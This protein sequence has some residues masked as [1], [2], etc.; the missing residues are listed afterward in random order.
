VL[1]EAARPFLTDTVYKREKHPFFGPPQL[2]GRILDL[3]R[4]TLSS[5]ILDEQPFFDAGAVRKRLEIVD[6]VEGRA[7]RD[8][9]FMLL[10]APMCA[11]ILQERY[12]L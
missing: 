12:R 3:M 9:E 8:Q 11:C 7:Q 1:R 4:D 10:T 5:R 6:A 2:K